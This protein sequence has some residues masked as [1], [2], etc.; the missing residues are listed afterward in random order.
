M[1]EPLYVDDFVG[2]GTTSEEVK[3]LW[4]NKQ[5]IVRGEIQAEEV[6]NKPQGCK[7]EDPD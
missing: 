3:D 6:V 5:E 2:E 1:I 4:E 7:R